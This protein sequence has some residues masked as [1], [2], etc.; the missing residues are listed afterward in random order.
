GVELHCA[1]TFLQVRVGA[2]ADAGADEAHRMGDTVGRVQDDL[3]APLS[4][5]ERDQL[6]RL[7]TRLLE[8]HARR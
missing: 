6:T 5:A 7:L 3:L 4:T 1:S 2:A 8:H